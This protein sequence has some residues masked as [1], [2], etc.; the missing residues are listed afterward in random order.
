MKEYL[1]SA[2]FVFILDRIDEKLQ[3][4]LVPTEESPY[5][6]SFVRFDD[7]LLDDLETWTSLYDPANIV[8][9][10]KAPKDALFKASK[11][12]LIDNGQTLCFFKRCYGSIQVTQELTTYKKIHEAVLDARLN[13]C[14]LYGIV[15]DDCDFI[16]GLLFTHVDCGSRLLSA[17]GHPEEPDD[18][19]PAVRVRWMG[20]LETALSA[21]HENSIVWGDVKAANVL[22]HKN[23][24]AWLIDFGGGYTEGWVDKDVAGTVVGDFTGMTRLRTLLFPAK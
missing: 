7:D 21:L 18:L 5:W 2:F 22:I 17:R 8:I 23:E 6:S 24:D 3:P 1:Y 13:V 20:Q 9:S 16:L 10:H 4:R 12:V 11:K 15:M 19:T 14:R